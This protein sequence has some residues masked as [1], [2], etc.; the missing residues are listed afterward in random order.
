MWARTLLL[1]FRGVAA[2]SSLVLS[3]TV[4]IVDTRIARVENVLLPPAVIKGQPLPTTRLEARMEAFGI[5]GL[6]LAV[7]HDGR[8]EWTRGYGMADVA[9]ARRVTP[10]TRFQAASISKPVAAV[11]AL[12]LVER[13]A[14]SLD[15]DVNRY[16]SSW[17]V[18]ANGFTREKPVTLRALL[19]HS[20]GLTVHGFRGYA[21]GE[22]VPTLVQVLR[23]ESPEAVIVDTP[24]GA[25]WRYSGGGF[26][27]LQLLVEDV[28]GEPF[29]EAARALVLEPFG[30]DQ[31]T[32][33]QPLPDDLR[34]HAAT[35]YHAGRVPVAGGWH[36]YPEQAAAG[37][38][39]TPRDLARFAIELQRIAAGRSRRALNTELA[40]EMLHPQLEDWGLG[41]NVSGSGAATR[42][43]H[44]GAN[45]GFRC[46]VVGYRDHASGVAVMTNADT[47]D[48]IL[49]EVVRAIAK[50]YG[51][52]G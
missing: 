47:G 33:V 52:R 43:S 20:A 44:G 29:A 28:T 5:P 50:E 8:I 30:M 36:I 7:F 31:S 11:T 48:A 17:K 22:P 23:G 6:S 19:T 13:G 45:V 12:A 18:P 27:I 38:W 24:V 16:L 46:Y 4:Q 15:D 21:R 3:G 40:A 9:E 32:F 25:R 2:A 14:L 49:H 10:S 34:R 39:T 35:G 1:S 37:L 51:W 41:V 42:F 26:S